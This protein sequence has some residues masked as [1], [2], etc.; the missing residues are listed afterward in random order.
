MAN[1]RSLDKLDLNVYD[2]EPLDVLKKL[3]KDLDCKTPPLHSFNSGGYGCAFLQSPTRKDV[4]SIMLYYGRMIYH[5]HEDRLAIQMIHND[6]ASIPDL[7]YP[8]YTGHWPKRIGWTSH[9]IS[10]NTVMV[11][12]KGPN[13][14]ASFSGKTMLFDEQLPV[15]VVDVDGE[16]HKIYKG[17]NTYRRCLVMVD[18]DKEHS[19]VVDVFWVRGGENHRLI[20]ERRRTR[21]NVFR[22]DASRNRP[23]APMRAKTCPMARS[24]T[25]SR[26]GT[27]TAAASCT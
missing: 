1:G 15:R 18:V 8:T 3:K 6:V 23:K 2:K 13:R 7:G 19:Y 12:D 5:G 25:E 16:G 10:H 22:H 17:V 14:G 26:I 24:T 27:T 9:M 20:P 4:R 11:N 21:G